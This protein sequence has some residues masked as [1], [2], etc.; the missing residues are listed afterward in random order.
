MNP[1]SQ[2]SPATEPVTSL[3]PRQMEVVRAEDFM[4]LMTVEQAV[5]RKTMVNQFISQVLKE[6]IDGD[7]GKIPG[8]S[9][10]TLLKPGAEKLCSIFGL[11][12]RY[13]SECAVL[14]WTGAEHG[15]EP[16]FYFQYRCQLYKGDRFLGEAIG[17]ANSWEE[18]H[19]WRWVKA[20]DVPSTY[21]Q[22]EMDALSQRPGTISEFAF[23]IDKGETSGPYGKPAEYW[24]RWREAI[25]S[26]EARSIQR[27]T[28]KGKE[29]DA[30]EMGGTLYRIPNPGSADT[31]NTCQKVGQKR[32]LVAVV[33]VVTNCSDSFTQDFEPEAPIDTGGHAVGT[34]AAAD[35][36]RDR[37][38]A[39]ARD[40]E[41]AEIPAELR[42]YINNLPR[43]GGSKECFEFIQDEIIRAG[44]IPAEKAYLARIENWFAPF[45]AAKKDA[46][47]DQMTTQ[48]LVEWGEVVRLRA[49]KA[50]E[51]QAAEESAFGVAK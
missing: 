17:S 42:S 50:M 15:G 28:Q 38:V 7:Y 31:V 36:V 19:R 49:E 20:D 6:G 10:P 12:P 39:Q 26:R 22:D 3:V 9:K 40:P 37:K 45:K 4:P 43:K 41:S 34:Q 24:A 2:S 8:S 51:A 16:F 27:K 25:N 47:L 1:S 21:S 23:A 44:G 32:A 30:W 29:M 5:Q 11:S 35:A 14:D 46:T 13:I 33:L 48:A 18:K